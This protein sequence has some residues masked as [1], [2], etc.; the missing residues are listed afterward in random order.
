MHDFVNE[1][2]RA[3]ANVGSSYA[4]SKLL[5]AIQRQLYNHYEGY[6]ATFLSPQ[7]WEKGTAWIVTDSDR[8]GQF[9]S[10]V[11]TRPLQSNK[12]ERYKAL[13]AFGV[14]ARSFGRLG[15]FSVMDVG[16]S[17][18]ADLNH[19]ASGVGF[20]SPTVVRPGSVRV[21]PS[22][23]HTAA[24]S[25]LM[26]REMPLDR[27]VGIDLTWPEDSREWAWSCSHYPSELLDQE[28]VDFFNA[29]IEAE[30]PEVAFFK[31]DFAN[32]ND[33]AFRVQFAGR[34]TFKIVHFC[35][36]LYQASEAERQVMLDRAA[37]YA[38]DF[39][40]VQ[41]FV[42]I[43]PDDPTHLI[44]RDNWQD[45]PHPYRMVI[46]DMRSKNPRR[47]QE[48]FLWRDG[49]CREL[50]VGLGRIALESGQTV[51]AWGAINRLAKSI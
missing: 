2:F 49:R 1:W 43:D 20:Q 36:M 17:Q 37:E 51:S 23:G 5:R 35:T 28:R 30:Y 21:R 26:S 41:D 48:V 22:L 8:F 50:Q 13:K 19:L 3:D 25:T 29:L 9:W 31:G 40:A 7:E 38:E 46:R 15:L 34:D 16:A 10:D 4:A 47:W 27:S 32:F 24:F 12:S 18:N 33:E 39:V 14:M 45:E 44:F 11:W 6:P 42:G